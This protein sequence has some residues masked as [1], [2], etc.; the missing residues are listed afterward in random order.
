M[1]IASTGARLTAG[2]SDALNLSR[3]LHQGLAGCR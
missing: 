3:Q 1:A 2:L